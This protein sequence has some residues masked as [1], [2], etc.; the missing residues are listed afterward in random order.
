M[1]SSTKYFSHF[2]RYNSSNNE[3][4]F[5]DI[6]PSFFKVCTHFAASVHCVKSVRIRSY[7]GPHFPAFELNTERYRVSLHFQSQCGK[8][9]TRI[10]PNTVTFYAVVVSLL[11]FWNN[12]DGG[13]GNLKSSENLITLGVFF[14]LY[15]QSSLIKLELLFVTLRNRKVFQHTRACETVIP[16]IMTPLWSCKLL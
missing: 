8:M 2:C 6:F 12:D 10:T 1:V 3:H 7:S 4:T 5:S 9:R 11:I 13:K 14:N 15:S 16:T